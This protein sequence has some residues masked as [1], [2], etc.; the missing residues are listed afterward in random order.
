MNTNN[1]LEYYVIH[2][3]NNNDRYTNIK[4][5][6]QILNYKINIFDGI[7]SA[8]FNENYTFEKTITEYDKH[9]ELNFIPKYKGIIGCYLSHYLLYKQLIN[10]SYLY[11][12]IFED[13]FNLCKTNT[14]EIICNLLNENT[15]DFDYLFIGYN[16]N[17]GNKISNNLCKIKNS[18]IWGFHG[19]IINNKKI[20]KILNLLTFLK[21]EIDIQIFKAIKNNNCIG[22]LFTDNIIRQQSYTSLIRPNKQIP[23][24]QIPNE[25]IPNEQIPNEQIPNEQIPNKQILNKQI[26]NK[27][28]PNKQILNK[29]IPNEQIP[30]EQIPNEQIPN[31]QILNKQIL[32][33]QIPN[34]QILNKQIPNEQIPNEQIP[35]E[36]IP[37][38]QILNKQI[39][40]KQIPNKQILNKQIPNEQIPN[41]QI[42]NKQILNKQIL[43]KQIL[44]KQIP[45]KQ[46]PNKQI[47]NK[48]I[49]N[50]QIPNKQIPNNNL[51]LLLHKKLY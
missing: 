4:N 45:N 37:N 50:K 36:Q 34:K 30:N 42:P 32:N 18:H 25:Q 51:L 5:M 2:L 41:E 27:Q 43:N 38:K 1:L 19:Y 26:L 9:L 44:N 10:S 8:K 16:G 7:D 6:E 40:N 35:N 29:Q 3:T 48:Q 24:E 17:K 28:I 14:H 11:T 46:I 33:K 47:P 13:D 15:I 20:L 23:N 39:L 31:K 22:Y 49:P 21:Y 12:V